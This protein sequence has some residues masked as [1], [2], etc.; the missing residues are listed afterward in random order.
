MYEISGTGIGHLIQYEDM[1][2]HQE[3]MK[4]Q[5]LEL[6]T[7]FSIEIT[8]LIKNEDFTLTHTFPWRMSI[9]NIN[10]PYTVY[11]ENLPY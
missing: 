8:M 2:A 5:A 6:G 10:N 1:N 3:Y 11:L 9:H 7:H 4:Y